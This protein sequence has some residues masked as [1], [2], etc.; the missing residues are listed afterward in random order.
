MFNSVRVWYVKYTGESL[1][2]LKT[3]IKD[4]ENKNALRRVTADDPEPHVQLCLYANLKKKL[5]R[6]SV[7]KLHTTGLLF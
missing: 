1:S 7:I 6:V 3:V 4:D 5:D 2:F